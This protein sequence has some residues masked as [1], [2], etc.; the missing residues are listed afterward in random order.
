MVFIINDSSLRPSL[1]IENIKQS[2]KIKQF[3]AA[4]HQKGISNTRRTIDAFKAELAKVTDQPDVMPQINAVNIELRQIRE[5]R[6]QIEG[7][8]SDLRRDKDNLH[9]ETK[10]EFPTNSVI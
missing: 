4:D 3:E 9:A 6:T 7:E 5:K 10:S 8:K 2:Q 1:Q